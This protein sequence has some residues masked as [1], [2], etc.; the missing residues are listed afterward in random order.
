VQDALDGLGQGLDK[1]ATK[2]QF[3]QY[4]NDSII[5]ARDYLHMTMEEYLADV[6]AAW[7]EVEKRKEK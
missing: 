4:V 2:E 7:D 5:I 3:E 1:S 6:N